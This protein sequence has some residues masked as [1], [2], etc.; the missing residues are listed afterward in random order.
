MQFFQDVELTFDQVQVLARGLHTLAAT[1]GVHAREE[2]LIREFYDA[3]RPAGGKSYEET[4]KTPFALD[5]ALETL[6]RPE[7]RRLFIKTAWLLAFADGKIT[8]P[9]REKIAEYA[10]ALNVTDAESAELQAQVKEFLLSQLTHIRN[11]A[12]L[13]DVA[14][15]MKVL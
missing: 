11:T 8:T 2:S 12:A 5:E 6:Q 14:R 9:E 1:D 4:V 13:A 10:R 7:H 15:S 3:C